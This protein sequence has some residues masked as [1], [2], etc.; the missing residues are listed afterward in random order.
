MIASSVT[1]VSGLGDSN[2]KYKPKNNCSCSCCGNALDQ[3]PVNKK[4]IGC[5][6]N[7]KIC[8]KFNYKISKAGIV[9]K[10][11]S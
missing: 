11:C 7:Y 3:Q 8:N 2:G 5:Y 6:K 1:G 4:K 10:T 9:G